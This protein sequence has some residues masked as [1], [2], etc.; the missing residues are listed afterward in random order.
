VLFDIR[1]P[2]QKGNCDEKRLNAEFEKSQ[3]LLKVICVKPSMLMSG[4][5]R[6]AMTNSASSNSIVGVTFL[7]FILADNTCPLL[8]IIRQGD[9]ASSGSLAKEVEIWNAVHADY[10]RAGIEVVVMT[11]PSGYMIGEAFEHCICHYMRALLRREGVMI[12]FNDP[13]NPKMTECPA[14]TNAQILFLD[15]ASHHKL[16]EIKFQ[17][18]CRFRNLQLTPFPFNTTNVSQPLDQQVNKFF[19][20]W[21][22]QMFLLEM[23]I[24]M[25]G[26]IRNPLALLLWANQVPMNAPALEVSMCVELDLTV[27]LTGNLGMSNTVKQLNATLARANIDGRRFD[28]VR[29][30]RICCPAWI[31]ALKYARQSF[32]AVGLAAPDVDLG[33]VLRHGRQSHL[34]L[35][36]TEEMMARYEVFPERI[37]STAVYQNAADKWAKFQENAQQDKLEL[38]TKGAQLVGAIP[39]IRR[40]ALTLGSAAADR[41]ERA[42]KAACLVFGP[43]PTQDAI[44]LSKLLVHASTFVQE[45]EQRRVR[46][47]AYQRRM[48]V[49]AVNMQDQMQQLCDAGVETMQEK[50]KTVKRS[51]E[52]VAEHAN[53]LQKACSKIEAQWQ[54]LSDKAELT[55]SDLK[56]LEGLLRSIREMTHHRTKPLD[57]RLKDLQTEL[58]KK[59]ESRTAFIEKSRGNFVPEATLKEV[60]GEAL[61]EDWGAGTMVRNADNACARV[62]DFI[63]VEVATKLST[64][65]SS[66]DEDVFVILVDI[67]GIPEDPDLAART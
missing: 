22:K 8:I 26:G 3:R 32:V 59:V 64:F 42:A 53:V 35:E 39:D 30:A 15:N 9:P 51:F 14:L 54:P 11:T 23:E 34:Q 29:V 65:A 31:A 52:I 6:I 63:C 58:G 18:E 1:T 33:P 40:Q 44:R 17:C 5:G 4:R 2:G 27:D 13:R 36:H 57:E 7:P 49:E 66:V 12:T 46:E 43:H 19:A 20:Q 56:K 61:S 28:E 55:L 24:E 25:S 38:L 10:E 37:T 21:V 16:G 60:L 48:P 47:E 62:A 45:D 50:L 67:L 41:D